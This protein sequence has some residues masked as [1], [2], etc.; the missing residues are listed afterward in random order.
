MR[1]PKLTQAVVAAAAL[2]ALAP[3][4]ASGAGRH[5]HLNAPKHPG[6]GGCR[7][8]LISEPH[9]ITSGE[10]VQLFGQ[11]RCPGSTSTEGKTVTVFERA[12]TAGKSTFQALA[13]ATTGAG[14][15]YSAIASNVTADSVYYASALGA[16]SASKLVKVAPAVTTSVVGKSPDAQLFTGRRNS[17][18]FTGTVSPGDAGAELVLQR[19]NSTSIEEWHAIQ[20]AQVNEGEKYTFTHTFVVPGDANIR[21]VVRADG[22]FTVRGIS[23]S[24]SFEISQAENEHLTINSES[25][26]ISYGQSTKISGT[27]KEGASQKVTLFSRPRG[28]STFTKV[29]EATTDGSGEYS[30]L[31]E[32]HQNTI[33]RASGLERTSAA[34]FEGVKYVLTAG[35]SSRTV[36][37]GQSLTF[38]GTVTPGEGH[39]VYLERENA[40]GHGFH[41]VDAATVGAKS[42]YSITHFVFG[43][44]PQVFRVKVPGNPEN[45]SV[46]SELFKEEVTPAPLGSL[47]PAPPSKSP[48]EGQV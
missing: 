1:S 7:I 17:V 20:F 48:S 5:P 32:P 35:V 21:V 8:D 42:T 30:F 25:D 37:A 38:S 4:T 19:E 9:T 18:V 27:L 24:L 10:S 11:L 14:G 41:V 2:L 46:S 45:Q 3:A 12:R 40:Y 28:S 13:T 23:E 43:A 15:S 36:Q 47:Q 16:R 44:G 22:K 31:V 33:Y 26:P 34:L 6:T 29:G 39:V